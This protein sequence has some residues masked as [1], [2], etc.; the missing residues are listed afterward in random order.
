MSSVDTEEW[1]FGWIDDFE[2][3]NMANAFTSKSS[4]AF[5]DALLPSLT[6]LC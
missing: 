6:L 3:F 1:P 5:Q 2:F 4:A